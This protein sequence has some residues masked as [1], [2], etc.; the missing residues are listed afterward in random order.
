MSRP[1]SFRQVERPKSSMTDEWLAQRASTP[2]GRQALRES[3]E[4]IAEM[5]KLSA[6]ELGRVLAALSKHG[7]IEA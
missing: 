1:P 4:R 2:E 5:I 7:G 3:A 6:S